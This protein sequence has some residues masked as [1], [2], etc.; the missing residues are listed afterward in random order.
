MSD[1]YPRYILSTMF[2]KRHESKLVSE[3]AWV[4]NKIHFTCSRA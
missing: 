4:A 2:Y 1:T 3:N